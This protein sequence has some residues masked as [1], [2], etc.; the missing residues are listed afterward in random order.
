[1]QGV[2]EGLVADPSILLLI[3]LSLTC[4]IEL[5]SNFKPII[6]NH[7]SQKVVA[8]C[9]PIFVFRRREPDLQECSAIAIVTET[10]FCKIGVLQTRLSGARLCQ[11]PKLLL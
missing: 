11:V 4:A 7:A 6:L 3:A 1:M 8:D 2:G 5:L 10:R 9:M